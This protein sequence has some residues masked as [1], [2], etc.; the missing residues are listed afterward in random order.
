MG[1]I[2]AKNHLVSIIQV[3]H[4]DATATIASLR[5][6]YSI[7]FGHFAKANNSDPLNDAAK[8]LG[9]TKQDKAIKDA[10]AAGH[11]AANLVN[12]YIGAASGKFANQPQEVQDVYLS[13]IDRAVSA[14]EDSLINS[15]VFASPAPKSDEEK[16]KTKQAKQE[17]AQQ[18]QIAAVQAAIDAGQVVPVSRVSTLT[19]ADL[20]E[21]ELVEELLYRGIDATKFAAIARKLNMPLLIAA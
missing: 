11:T 9:K 8:L 3:L 18:A 6:A 20:S 21:L 15:G 10:I 19:M 5:D 2:M 4:K 16:A 17:K 14:F 1:F 13:A 12:G 7:E